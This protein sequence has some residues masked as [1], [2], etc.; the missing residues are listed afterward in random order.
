MNTTGYIINTALVLLVVRQIRG[1]RLDFQNLALP[2]VLV[3][4]AAAYYLHS[5]PIVGHDLALDVALGLTGAVLGSLCGFFTR[6]HSD[7][8]GT[9]IARAG[10]AAAALWVIGVG[11]RMAF[12]FSADHGGRP[13]ITHFSRAHSISGANAWVAALVLMA[14]AE[15]I[16][17]LVVIRAR[18]WRLAPSFS[19]TAASNG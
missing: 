7:R 4:A 10:I 8:D 19:E 12:A 15:V 14:L 9:I 18:A 3:G 16:A 5:I 13:A 11:A 2:L 1:R 6:F 17:R